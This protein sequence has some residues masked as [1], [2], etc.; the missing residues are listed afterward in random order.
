MWYLQP[1]LKLYPIQ[2]REQGVMA[3]TEVV[4]V[5]IFWGM[6]FVGQEIITDM[7][8]ICPVSTTKIIDN[9]TAQ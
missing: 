4:G 5:V 1:N 6:F 9:V 3:Q 7:M 8:I 2:Q